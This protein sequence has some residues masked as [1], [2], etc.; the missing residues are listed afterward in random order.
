MKSGALTRG[1]RESVLPEALMA[2]A[3][4]TGTAVVQAAG[5]DAWTSFRERLSQML[6]RGEEQATSG[7]LARLD[8]TADQLA[9]AD[10]AETEAV[11]AYQA[12]VWRTRVELALESLTESQRE[13]FA[14]ELR[15]AVEEVTGNDS[16]R[17]VWNGSVTMDGHATGQAR[18]YQLGQGT[19]NI[20]ES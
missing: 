4:M 14:A 8:R 18:M 6:A 16:A 1:E 9:S 7:E 20:S 15:A 19:M 3:A 12:G 2:V 5:T 10:L 13:A 11:R 17:Q